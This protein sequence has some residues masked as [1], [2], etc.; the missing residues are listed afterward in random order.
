MYR[1]GLVFEDTQ[2]MTEEQYHASA[3]AIGRVQAK[4]DEAKLETVDKDKKRQA[5]M[6]AFISSD[7]EELDLENLL[8]DAKDE[9]N[10]QKPAPKMKKC[11]VVVK[12]LDD[13]VSTGTSTPVKKLT[14]PANEDVTNKEHD[15][16][17]GAEVKPAKN[18]MWNNVK[19]VN[20]FHLQLLNKM[21][22]RISVSVKVSQQSVFQGQTGTQRQ[23][24]SS[25][26]G[27]LQS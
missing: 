22:K 27:I 10:M 13:I 23:L 16:L 17:A 3:E 21:Q 24:A 19:Q 4:F 25:A 9:N 8:E 20:A 1:G 6:Q 2:P 26:E 5:W 14:G 15:E 7:E 11:M 12:R 18:K